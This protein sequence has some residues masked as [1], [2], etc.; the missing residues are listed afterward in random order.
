MKTETESKVKSQKRHPRFQYFTA[1]LYPDED[2]RH[3]KMIDYIRRH[4]D[5][6]LIVHDK[7]T[8]TEE[9]IERISK[10]SEQSD[11]DEFDENSILASGSTPKVGDLKKKHTHIVWK[12]YCNH[13]GISVQTAYKF[14]RPWCSYVEKVTN[15]YNFTCYLIHDTPSSCHKHQYSPDEV[16]MSDG[17]RKTI[18]QNKN[19]A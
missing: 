13:N 14:F 8:W 19:F 17:Y 7:D 11:D 1:I 5:Y 6:A 15:V 2:I 4:F 12:P 3:I 9:D 10:S 18:I 16:E